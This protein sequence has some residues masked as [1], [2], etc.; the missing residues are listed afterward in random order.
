MAGR[1]SAVAAPGD[2][3]GQQKTRH[4][5]S[6]PLF[7]SP[8]LKF[9]T[10]YYANSSDFT[11]KNAGA[12][13]GFTSLRGSNFSSGYV[14]SD[15][16]QHSF[17]D[18]LRH[19]LFVQ[20]EKQLSESTALSARLSGNF[21]DND[22]TNLNGGL[23]VRY[24]PAAN[25]FT[26]IS[27]RHFDIIDTVL[28]F[29]NVIYNYVV[30]IGSVVRNIRTDDYKVYLL[31]Y[32][33]AKVSLA[34]EA[35]YGDYSDGNEKRSLMLEA[36]YQ[37]LEE[38][39]F[40]VAY[41]FFYLDIKDPAPIVQNKG[42]V[43][44]AYWDP[45]NFETHTLRLDLRKDYNRHLSLGAEAALS[46]TPKSRGLSK[47]AFL[48]ASYRLTDQSSLHFDARWFDQDEGVER[49]DEGDRFWAVNYAVSFQYT[50]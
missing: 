47:S 36:G 8:S 15:F 10:D 40:R 50:F 12:E 16:S 25:V 27:Y 34:G 3:A 39:F 42:A 33:A 28:P 30:T 5:A 4:P 38:P 31:Y 22:H 20:G 21:Y 43:E 49:S 32:P 7:T 45:T 26:E 35:V 13:L 24:N 46:Y 17:E 11:R 48:S 19:T 44:S 18:I 29:N 37:V 23:F 6:S 41:N 2:S 1:T 9:Q 14:F